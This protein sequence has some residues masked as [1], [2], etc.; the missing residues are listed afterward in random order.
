MKIKSAIRILQIAKRGLFHFSLSLT[1]TQIFI[2]HL[3]LQRWVHLIGKYFTILKYLD[4]EFY[5]G[6]SQ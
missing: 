4:Y 1:L 2:I 6:V 3:L 5:Q